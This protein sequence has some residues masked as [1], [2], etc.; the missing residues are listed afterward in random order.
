MFKQKQKMG[1]SL[2][3]ECVG[4][5]HD[6]M[7]TLEGRSEVAKGFWL[8]WTRFSAHLIISSVGLAQAHPN[9]TISQ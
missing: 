2:S 8:D 5:A 1:N 3:G 6:V 4:G 7:L 9:N